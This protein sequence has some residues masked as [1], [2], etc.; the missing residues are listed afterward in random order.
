MAEKPEWA[1]RLTEQNKR[2]TRRAFEE[3]LEG[4]DYEALEELYAEDFLKH[5]G[6]AGSTEGQDAFAEYVRNLHEAFPDFT[7]TEELC[8]CAGDFVTTVNTHRGTH[9]GS[10]RGVEP[11]GNEFEVVTIVVNRVTD[12]KITEAWVQADTL[13]LLQQIGVVELPNE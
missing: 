2:I 11:S 10:F 9:D 7:V 1:Q 6:L 13:A 8:T 5:G 12:G 3:V 4:E